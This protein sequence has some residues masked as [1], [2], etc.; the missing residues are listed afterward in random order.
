[1]DLQSSIL[2]SIIQFIHLSSSTAITII[3]NV[4]GSYEDTRYIQF[5]K[6]FTQEN[7]KHYVLFKTSVFP[8]LIRTRLIKYFILHKLILKSYLYKRFSLAKNCCRKMYADIIIFKPFV[9][10]LTL[11]ATIKMVQVKVLLQMPMTKKYSLQ[12]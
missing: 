8:F 1:M 2:L 12:H 5:L 10:V 4:T 6:K 7:E 11:K 9:Q 3:N